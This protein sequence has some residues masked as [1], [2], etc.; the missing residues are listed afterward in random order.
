[1]SGI[2][3]ALSEIGTGLCIVF[4]LLVPFA[5][6]GLALI[7]TGLGRSRSAAHAMLSSLCVIAV[8][9]SV[10]V[11]FGFAFQGYI[12]RPAHILTIAG[13]SWSWIAADR[14]FLRGLQL[15]GSAASLV[16]WLQMFS[17][18]LVALIP[19]G[20]GADRWRLS[21]SCVTTALM[22]GWIYPL[23]AHWTW[24]GGWL[25]QLGTNY[26]LGNGFLDAGG[27]GS[28]QVMGG[29][30][31]LSIS[32]ILGPRRGKYTLDGMPAAI[33]GHNSVL[34]LF[35][36]VLALLGWV[37][38]NSAGA[39]LFAGTMPG[40]V[41]L[42]AINTTLSAGA[43]TLACLIITRIRF[44]K[45][46]ASLCANGWISGLVAS[47]ASCAFI[48]PASAIMVGAVA[49]A[50]ATISVQLFE[51]IAVD[52]PTGAISVHGI[53]GI[54][55]LLA[56]ALF[57][58]FGAHGGSGQLTAQLIG[59]ATLLGFVLP[60]TYGLNALVNRF[61][62]YR[63]ASEGERQGMDLY[64]LGA[65]AYPEFVTYREEFTQH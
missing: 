56:V 32:W 2:A 48:N 17:V 14:F 33:P 40:R 43:A 9:A 20:S 36:C 15:D 31:A 22:A 27:T 4:I 44:G 19:L 60:L 52:D 41:V 57:V 35:G 65:G 30:H 28:I 39:M 1:M 42:I 37:G 26:G 49:G 53:A 46:D 16:A 55:G 6:A 18:A 45:P 61:L 64:E 25:A 54:W 50:L 3:P 34:V 10:Y 58:A 63:V 38:L 59:L 8:A 62:P 11:I 5:F 21:A 23:F 13:K 12:G 7:N 47:S 51:Q 29:L 24:G